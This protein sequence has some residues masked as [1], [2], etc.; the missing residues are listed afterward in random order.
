MYQGD[1]ALFGSIPLCLPAVTSYRLLPP[2][3]RPPRLVLRD[4][5][6]LPLLRL[7]LRDPARLPLLRLV[8]A[9]LRPPRVREPLEL[10]LPLDFFRL[11]LDVDFRPAREREDFERDAAFRPPFL[12]RLR[13]DV[14]E[15]RTSSSSSISSS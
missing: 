10:R 1:A 14:R 9:R 8:L 7:V 5:L 15:L 11:R 2:R 4:P 13:E 6:R 3:L 12:L